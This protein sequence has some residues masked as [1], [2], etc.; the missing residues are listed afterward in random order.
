MPADI[1]NCQNYSPMW[2]FDTKSKRCRQFY[3][4]GCG[5]NENRF[6]TESECESQCRKSDDERPAPTQAPQTAPPRR[7]QT[8]APAPSR[9]SVA[10]QKDHCLLDVQQGSC[11]ERIRRFYFDRTYGVCSQFAYTGCD[12]NE[13]NF[14]TLQECE[15][16]CNDAVELCDLAPLPGGC[17][18]N[19]T[20]WYF[21][22]YTSECQTFEYTGCY[23]NKNNFDDKRS[24]ERACHHRM[25]SQET[26]PPV[27]TT[28]R[29]IYVIEN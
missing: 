21:D 13:N 5:G 20:K 8:E 16:L 25:G 19:E 4:G 6:A 3:Y 14:E 23:G 17:D 10:R 9:P 29:P 27:H 28:H 1:G 18:Q 2:Y 11:N 12:G 22:P 7:P 24:C 26:Y 15:E